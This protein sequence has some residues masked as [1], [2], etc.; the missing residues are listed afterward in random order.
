MWHKLKIKS[1]SKRTDFFLKT[2]QVIAW[3][4]FIGVCID[5]GGVLTNTIYSIFVN[6]S[7]AAHF[8][9]NNNLSQVNSFN[10]SYFITLT[11]LMSIV[12]ILKALLFYIII[13]IFHDKKLNFSDPFKEAIGP[14]VSNIAYVALGIGLFSLW[15]ADLSEWLL[16]QNLTISSVQ[17]LKLGGADVWF[18]MGFTML[19]FAKI[20]KKGIELQ[21]END[22]T[23]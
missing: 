5:A 2:L 1:M 10:Q 18:L 15:G 23:V 17:K 6:P 16:K 20:F 21:S 4:I 14:Y 8:W 13:K 3:I 9:N 19:V 7:L 11:T 22:L 12:A